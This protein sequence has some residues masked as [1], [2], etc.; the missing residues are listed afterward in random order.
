[1]GFNNN[2]PS[3]M[4]GGSRGRV[5]KFPR[6]FNILSIPSFIKRGSQLTGFFERRDP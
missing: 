5:G 4:K 3:L 6:L 2:L 1:M